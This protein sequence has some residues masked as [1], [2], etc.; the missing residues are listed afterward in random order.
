MKI[1]TFNIQ[2]CLDYNY[3]LN[4]KT[5][6]INFDVMADAIKEISPDIVGLEEVRGD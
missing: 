2:H 6:R 5:E 3:F 4:N 1:M